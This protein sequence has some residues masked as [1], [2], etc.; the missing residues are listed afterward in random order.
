MRGMK[1]T[2]IFCSILMPAFVAIFL[3]AGCEPENFNFSRKI[4]FTAATSYKNLPGTKTSYSGD[5]EFSGTTLTYERIDWVNN[6]KIRITTT[7][8]NSSAT[9]DYVVSSFSTNT[10]RKKSDAVVGVA[11]GSQ[12]LTW[13]SDDEHTFYAMYPSP[14]TDGVTADL[15]L[16]GNVIT[17]SIPE[18]QNGTPGTG[19]NAKVYTPNMYNAYMWAATRTVPTSDGVALGFSPLM[20]AFEFTVGAVDGATLNSKS[21]TLESTT[22][23]ISGSYK[24][25]IKNDL[26]GYTLSDISGTKKITV[27]FGTAGV[28]VT[29]TS[30][31]KFTVFAI[32][33]PNLTNL[34]M[35]FTLSD[36]SKSVALTQSGT[37][38]VFQ[39][40]KKYRISNVYVPETE[41]FDYTLEIVET[42]P[43]KTYG[44]VAT[45]STT[46]GL[47]FTVKSYKTSSLSGENIAVAWKLQYKVGSTWTDFTSTNAVYDGKL[48]VGTFNG[49]GGTT[50]EAVRADIARDHNE[51]TEYY[52][53]GS[54]GED[55][56]TAILRNRTPLPSSTSD[57]G[58]GYFDLSKHP[59][60]GTIDGPEQLQETANCYVIT[61]AGKYKLP[62]VYGNA[63]R[64]GSTNAVAYAPTVASGTNDN[65]HYMRQFLRHDDNPITNPWL[66]NNGITVSDAVVVWQDG[67]TSEDMQ[68]LFKN[69]I[70]VSD[71]YIKFEIRKDKIRPGNIVLAARN[72]SGTIVWSWHLWVT[73]KDLT[74]IAVD[75][76][77]PNSHQM[78]RYNLGW[79]DA[80]SASGY[81]WEDWDLP[82]RI[83]Q[84]E[85]GQVVGGSLEFNVEQHG[86]SGEVDP[87][88]GSN[89]FYQWGRK[90]PLL[91]AN[92]GNSNRPYYTDPELGYQIL[93]D[94]PSE[95]GKQRVVYQ[96]SPI[97]ESLFVT[98]G[99]S[100]QHPNIQYAQNISKYGTTGRIYVGGKNADGGPIIGNLWDANMIPYTNTAAGTPNP[101]DNRLTV[102]TVYDPCPPGFC[103][104]Y[105][106]AFSGIIGSIDGWVYSAPSGS[107]YLASQGWE[108]TA[109]GGK[110]FFPFT[111]ARGGN[112]NYIY[113]VSQ[114]GFYW[115][116][117]PCNFIDPDWKTSVYAKHL[118][119]EDNVKLRARHEQDR[120]AAYAVRPV[121]QVKFTN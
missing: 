13:L 105:G 113:S 50:G 83:V 1:T 99:H 96:T 63:I 66:S 58:D 101:Y 8:G 7:D 54:I 64:A 106:R 3:L 79:T 4:T 93:E 69:D 10:D 53:H 82:L 76:L 85:G 90:D 86:E 95:P 55:T 67:S 39:Q 19:A 100:I 94:S 114:L 92:Y 11:S 75:D 6:D 51:S 17:A 47:P 21:F 33:Q 62:L 24:A 49:I 31:V 119:L 111:G 104:P 103:V 46:N 70:T 29:K 74:P 27:S 28:N 34:K 9:S 89:T 5:G 41:T 84:V 2:K 72:S 12:E 52:H 116:S 98:V 91:P 40:G 80:T 45:T 120:A 48:K 59:V 87:N 44:H 107:R 30:P 81:K 32:P 68:I 60:Y 117:Q 88:V 97:N 115:T 35:T 71:N 36:G 20:T 108:F 56:G 16:S 18:S 23:T 78:M 73:E 110:L 102:K 109:T 118:S 121:L 37:P 57:A 22:M 38:A 14:A 65:N 25:T 112:G 77:T 42:T 43:I 26:S 15:S 61:A